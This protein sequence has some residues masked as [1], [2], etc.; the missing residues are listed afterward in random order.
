MM[1]LAKTYWVGAFAVLL[2]ATHAARAQDAKQ[3]VQQAVN[4]QLA[5]DRNDTSHWRYVKTEIDRSKSVVVE[6]ETGAISRHIEVAGQPAS[7]QVL[8]QDDAENQ[9]FIHDP[10]LRAKQMQNGAHDDK[11]SIE[12]LNLMPEAFV[13]TVESQTPELTTLSFRPKPNFSPPDM[14]AR[15]MGMMSGTLV[16]TNPRH[17]IKTFKGRLQHDVTIGFGL[18]ARIKAGSTFDIERREVAPGYWQIAETHVHIGGHAL[19]FKTISEQEDEVKSDFTL[20]PPGTTLEQAIDMLKEP[21]PGG[22][23]TTRKR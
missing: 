12:L 8:A 5:A 22:G 9:R 3:I 17:R 7:A 11:A 10:S 20:V 19:F 15:V 2:V 21:T 16:V 18:L 6:T 13:W 4:D 1:R 23:R 14:E